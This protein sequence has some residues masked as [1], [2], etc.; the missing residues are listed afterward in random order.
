[1]TD[2]LSNRFTLFFKRSDG[3]AKH[4]LNRC[5]K[6]GGQYDKTTHAMINVPGIYTAYIGDW[7]DFRGGK[8][9]L[10]K[11]DLIVFENVPDSAPQ[12][13]DDFDALADKYNDGSRGMIIANVSENVLFDGGAPWSINHIEVTNG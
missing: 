12:S 4:V 13:S 11:G 5:M 8:Y 10:S 6:T 7:E 9:T 1:M 3:Y 2:F